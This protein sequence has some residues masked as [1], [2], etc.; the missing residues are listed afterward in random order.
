[1]ILTTRLFAWGISFAAWGFSLQVAAQTQRVVDITPPEGINPSEVSIAINPQ[2]EGNIVAVSMMRHL[3][4]ENGTITNYGYYTRDGGKTWETSPAPNPRNRIQ[5]DDAIRFAPDGTALRA[6]ISFVGIF[7]PRPERGESAIVVS[8]SSD[9][10]ATWNEPVAV[11]EHLNTAEPMEDKEYL[12][13]DAEPKSPFYGRTYVTWTRF[14]RYGSDDPEDNTQIYFSRSPDQG[15]T[16]TPP[17]RISDLGGDCLDKDD[18]VEGAVPA[19]GTD[20]RIFVVWSGPRGM[21]LDVSLDG[22]DTWSEDRKIYDHP[23]G[24]DSTVAGAGRHNGMPVT[25]VDHSSGPYRGS[26][27]V[28]WIDDRNGDL[29]VFVGQSRDNGATW[30]EPVRVNDDPIKNGK[31][32]FFTWMAVD[33]VDGSINAIFYDRRDQEGLAAR[34]TLARSVDGGRTFRN[35]AVDQPP[36]ELS[37]NVFMGDYTGIDARN[38]L[39]AAAWTYF[40]GDK[41][42]TAI[43]A[44]LFRFKLGTAELI[45][46]PGG[47]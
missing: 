35:F 29:D 3:K 17:I 47:K 22:G 45:S 37:D 40:T 31:E 21:E 39:V 4:D 14:D 26:L 44:G 11:I 15:Q 9:G 7:T 25:G 13:V 32:Q 41:R 2:E 43:A 12:V 46:A 30:S 19:V 8:R 42:Q 36:F 33:P 1:M 18:T 6:Y 23:G 24:W 5:G 27:Y 38:G 20:G 28:N 10:G 16:F 34:M